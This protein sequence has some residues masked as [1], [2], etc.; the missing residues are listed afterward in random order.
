MLSV[1]FTW[2][3]TIN[4]VL[5]GC[6]TPAGFLPVPARHPRLNLTAE[7]ELDIMERVE[8]GNYIKGAGLHQFLPGGKKTLQNFFTFKKN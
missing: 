5:L 4:I 2:T 3:A 7:Q 8:T 6:D 1:S